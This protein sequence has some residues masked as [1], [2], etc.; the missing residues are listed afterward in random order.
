MLWASDPGRGV[1]AAFELA[2]RLFK[3]NRKFKLHVCWPDYSSAVSVSHP[4]LKFH[5]NLDNGP[6]LWDLFGSTG[7]LPY[8][9]GFME[10]SS[11]AHRQAMAAGSLVLYPPGM[12]TPSELIED[13]VTGLVRPVEEWAGHIMQSIHDGTCQTLGR[14]AREYAIS[15]NWAVQARR[16]NDLFGKMLEERK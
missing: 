2:V 8:T 7:I 13:G 10:P 15:E 16:F 14:Q 12:G 5:R 3:I 11:R 6:E 1:G 4:A 9:S